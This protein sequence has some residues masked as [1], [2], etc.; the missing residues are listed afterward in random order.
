MAEAWTQAQVFM[1]DR[2]ALP[3]KGEQGFE[4]FAAALDGNFNQYDGHVIFAAA[5]I[6]VRALAG[7]LQAKDRD[8]AV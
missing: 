6:V 3:T 4:R 7:L 1:P 5:G 2:L 8:P